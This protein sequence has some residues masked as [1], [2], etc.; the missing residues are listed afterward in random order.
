MRS[1]FISWTRSHCARIFS[2]SRA[3][4]IIP[5]GQ[6][7]ANTSTSLRYLLRCP[8]LGGLLWYIAS[9]RRSRLSCTSRS[10]FTLACEMIAM[11]RRDGTCTPARSASFTNRSKGAVINISP[12]KEAMR[13]AERRRSNLM[14]QGGIC[15]SSVFSSL[16]FIDIWNQ[17]LRMICAFLGCL[18]CN[19]PKRVRHHLSYSSIESS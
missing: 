18:C 17:V 6:S 5:G 3:G 9:R 12:F 19:S 8:M 4:C 1:P 16:P 10:G 2:S 13:S 7:L 14:K 11:M 15:Q